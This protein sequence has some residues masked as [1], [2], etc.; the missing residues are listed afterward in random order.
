MAIASNFPAIKPSLSLDFANTKKLDPR[1]TFTR[2]TTA[3]YYDGVTTA[4]AEQNLLLQSQDF[5]TSWGA[6][7]LTVTANTTT[8]P[9]GTSTAETFD[10]GTATGAHNANQ[11]ISGIQGNTTYVFSCFLKNVN[12]QFA[13]LS[14]S[15]SPATYAGAKF[16][17]NAG[18]AG[19]TAANGS[20]WS[21]TSSSITSAGNSWYRCVLVF[22]PASTVTSFTV[23][24]GTATD[25]TTFTANERG[26]ESYTGT[27]SQIY[28][29]G[30]QLE[31]RS[32][33][34][35]YTATTTQAIT[36]YIPVLLTAASGV[37]RFQHNP[38]TDESLGLLIEEARTNLLVQSQDFDTAGWTKSNCS[39]TANT[40]VAPNGILTGDKVVEN[41][42]ASVTHVVQQASITITAGASVTLS[43]YVKAAER[44]RFEMRIINAGDRLIAEFN[45]TTGTVTNSYVTGTSTLSGATITNVGNSWY[46]ITVSGVVNASSTSVT[47]QLFMQDNSGSNTYTGD[48]YSGIYIWGAQFEAGAFPTSYI[49][50]TA[51]TVTRNA[52]A[53]SMTGSNFTSWYNQGE[54]AVY[55]ELSS[56]SPLTAVQ[57][58]A[59]GKYPAV[60]NF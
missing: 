7:N 13:T 4:K 15:D 54:G 5:T 21:V 57:S 60:F 10:D 56:L 35:A 26:Q 39:I 50:T 8:A 58:Y 2:T 47:A 53:A 20:G 36:N 41:T 45:T 6:T 30:A 25:G 22:V 3:T 55:T 32:S 40:V 59:L 24:V 12:R 9:D 28:V 34:T 14:V 31:Q 48:G 16:D 18:T 11:L 1:I 27:N 42:A 52:D 46:R 38:T 29:W 33:V 51:A 17:L 23:R 19:S 44:N 37:A 43:L 49:A